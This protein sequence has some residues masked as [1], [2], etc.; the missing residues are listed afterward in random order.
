MGLGGAGA[1]PRTGSDCFHSFYFIV[2]FW[3]I[4]LGG[5]GAGP[6]TGSNYVILNL[7]ALPSVQLSLLLV[8]F[9]LTFVCYTICTITIFFNLL[10]ELLLF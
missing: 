4:G 5:A 8:A 6:R 3:P 9:S 1:G 10:V 7:L 2:Y